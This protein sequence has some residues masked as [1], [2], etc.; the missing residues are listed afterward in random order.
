MHSIGIMVEMLLVNIWVGKLLGIV[1]T[2]V[3]DF[4]IFVVDSTCVGVWVNVKGIGVDVC[5]LMYV[6]GL[7]VVCKYM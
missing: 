2:H 3:E 7:C 4:N 5:G 1:D 6:P